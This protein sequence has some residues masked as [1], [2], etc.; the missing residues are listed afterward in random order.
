MLGGG[1]ASSPVASEN[2][3]ELIGLGKTYR[4]EKGQEVNALVDVNLTVRRGEIHGIVGQSG[5]GKS[6]LI[7]CL[8]ALE[9]PTSGQVIIDGTDVSHLKQSQLREARRNI[10]MVFQHANLLDSRTVAQNIAYPL[11]LAKRP[12]AEIKATVDRLLDFV[13][14][15]ARA[16]SYPS[17]LSG[18]QKQRVGIARA[19]AD[20]PPVVLCDEPTSALDTE[21]TRQILDL[22]TRLQR[23]LG[24]TI[25]IITHEMGVVREICDSVT[26]LEA[27]QVVQ[28]GPLSEIVQDVSSALAEEIVPFPSV[29]YADLNLSRDVLLDVRFT[30]QPG[31]PTGSAVLGLA[32]QLGADL[33]AGTFET[34]GNTQVGRLALT[35]DR[36]HLSEAKAAFAAQGIFVKEVEVA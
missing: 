21:T 17:E 15:T 4:S 27:G 9:Q 29:D 8:T 18:G 20:N 23:E 34:L 11:V 19:L 31:K 3:I 33:A 24:V 36:R 10:G 13:G 35:L 30:S 32:S 14:L 7:R 12:K 2:I 28:S 25:V 1:Q 16:N 6:T 26:L 5:A 22:L